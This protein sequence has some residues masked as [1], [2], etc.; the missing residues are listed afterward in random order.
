LTPRSPIVVHAQ[1]VFV[2]L[3][4]RRLGLLYFGALIL[5]LLSGGL[6]A[7]LG[8]GG[9][10]LYDQ[11]FEVI[12]RLLVPL[13]TALVVAPLVGEELERDTQTFVFVRRSRRNAIVWARLLVLSS[14]LVATLIVAALLWLAVMLR[15]PDQLLPSLGHLG[16]T[17]L[18]VVCAFAV[19][20]SL[21]AL[22][23]TVFFRHPVAAFGAFVLIDQSVAGAP[24]ALKVLSPAWHL[25][26]L[27]AL[28]LSE[29][30]FF[31]I[32]VPMFVSVLAVALL[33]TLALAFA[34]WRIE[35]GFAEASKE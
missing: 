4:R 12:F 7:W 15:F 27:A 33:A 35:R 31:Q 6:L 23:G 30:F 10:V 25:R 19:Y 3:F 26:R 5:P 17:E 32:D 34:L 20:G 14:Y 24:V 28:P 9:Q 8:S 11:L 29:S 22:L 2:R 18:G 13:L 1:L 16:R 21:G